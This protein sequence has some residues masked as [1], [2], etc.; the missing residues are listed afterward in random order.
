[1]RKYIVILLLF[2]SAGLSAQVPGYQGLRF[3][4]K[5]NLGMMHPAIVSRS[6]KAPMVYNNASIEYVVNRAWCIGVKYGFMTHTSPPK[7]IWFDDYVSNR[8][9]YKGNFTQHTAHFYGK[10]FFKRRGFI[11]PVGP[12]VTFGAYYQYAKNRF[13]TSSGGGYGDNSNV[14][15]HKAISHYAGVYFGMGRTFVVANR[16]L[17]DLGYDFNFTAPSP[18]IMNGSGGKYEIAF[19]EM[20]LRN[21]FQLHV[22]IGVLAF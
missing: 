8:L 17:I 15:E 18:S 22:G 10:Y 1:M 12:Y 7:K 13:Y 4:A 20:L 14:L 5:Y 6:G 16:L 3:I 2:I 9:D 19:N 21:L 11:A